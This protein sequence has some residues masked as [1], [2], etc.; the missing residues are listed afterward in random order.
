VRE[1]KRSSLRATTAAA[2]AVLLALLAVACGGDD[3]G[4]ERE[5]EIEVARAGKP[6]GELTI[7][8]WPGYIDPGKNGTVAEFEERFGVDVNHIEDITSNVTFFGKLQ[9]QLDQGDSGGRSLFVVTDWMAKQMYDLG[10]LM[11]FRHEDLKT[12]FDNILPEFEESEND[13]ER[14]YSIPWQGGLS[15]IWVDTNAAPEIRS[16]KDLFDPKYKGKVIFL[17]EMRDTLPLVMQSQGVE[18]GEETKQDWLN[19][20]ELIKDGLDSG[21]IRDITDQAYTEDLTAGNVVAAIGWSGDAS[22]IGREG[23]EWRQPTDGCDT[24]FDQM[25]IPVGAPNT[26]AAL[27]FMNFVYRPEVQADIAA[28]VNYVTPVDGVQEILRKRDP[29]LGNNPLIFPPPELTEGCSAD[30]NP[31][32]GPEAV[33]EVT[34]AFQDL[35]TG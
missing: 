15:G 35:I 6:T 12:V 4:G 1:A 28:W 9:P 7:S 18:V 20:I 5:G 34:A 22:L 19:A 26:E 14:K 24:F 33:Q 17:D 30:P 8:N 10:Y 13:P 31:P 3:V 23:V 27:A 25:V 21:Q 32:G 16:M 29:E 11:E 2:L